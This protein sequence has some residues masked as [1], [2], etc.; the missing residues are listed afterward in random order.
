MRDKLN[1]GKGNGLKI[2]VL[3]SFSIISCVDPI[4]FEA[5]EE[6]SSLVIFGS[7]SQLSEDHVV[8]IRRTE[9]FGN[10]GTN[11]SRALVEIEDEDGNLAK[12]IEVEEGKYILQQGEM[13]GEP[14]KA[15]KLS[16]TLINDH[17]FESAWELMPEPVQ[18]EKPKFEI[19]SRPVVSSVGVLVD[20]YF[21]DILVDTSLETSDGNNAM[22]RW[23]VDETF[24]ILDLQCGPFDNAD[25]CFF[26][27]ISLFDPIKIFKSSDNSQNKL[28]EFPVYS[29]LPLPYR[30]F[31][32]WHY[33]NVK[34]YS[35]SE[36]TYEYWDKIEV[37]SD[38][39]GSI[40]DKIPAKVPGN[41]ISLNGDSEVFGY[42]EVA[43][44]TI[45][46]VRVIKQDLTEYIQPINCSR[47]LSPFSQPAYCCSCFSLPNLIP[48]PVYWG[49][50]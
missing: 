28:E 18:M 7:F 45:G 44:V 40:F 50:Q 13:C 49:E 12:Y 1:F 34:Q 3:M 27:V 41:L 16:V 9:S 48:R 11:V 31:A 32:E 33:F 15:Y 19:K 22:F 42:F 26:E 29:R 10:L 20:E 38:Q 35:I 24:S 23:E 39:S 21:I 14:G 30:E 43:S 37:V 47:Y 5:E 36:S 17:Q 25:I 6:A 2:L 4:P 8:S 46:R